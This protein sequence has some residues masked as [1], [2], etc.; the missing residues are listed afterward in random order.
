[1]NI[2]ILHVP[3]PARPHAPDGKIKVE[4]NGQEVR[5]PLKGHDLVIQ[6]QR[7]Q[8]HTHTE[9]SKENQNV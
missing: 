8:F 6:V 9:M 7:I 4:I 2:R 3:D 1:M 5:L